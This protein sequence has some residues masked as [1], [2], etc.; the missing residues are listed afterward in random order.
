M[1]VESHE[2][3]YFNDRRIHM[4]IHMQIFWNG[5]HGPRT[6]VLARKWKSNSV[7]IKKKY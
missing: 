6:V 2:L 7:K 4:Q 3:L 5:I 1:F